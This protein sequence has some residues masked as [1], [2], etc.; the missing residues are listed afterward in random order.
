MRRDP[1]I[2]ALE[3]HDAARVQDFV[4][5][6]TPR[7][8]RERY[9]SAI[10]ELPPRDLERTLGPAPGDLSLAAVEGDAVIAIAECAR[11]EFAIVVADAWQGCGLG[12]KLVER[13]LEEARRRRLPA[14]HGLVR[15]GNRAMLR[16]AASFGFRIGRDPDP[17]LLQVELFLAGTGTG[18]A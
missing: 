4:R 9:F 17:E 10:R 6:L 11:G 16:L 7:S 8:R 14:L 1:A 18:F 2:R 3:P 13:L 15:R 12:R 5:S